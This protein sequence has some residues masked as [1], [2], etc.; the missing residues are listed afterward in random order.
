MWKRIWVLKNHQK[1]LTANELNAVTFERV[2]APFSESY[3]SLEPP[4]F[5]ALSVQ[6]KKTYTIQMEPMYE[7]YL[8]ISVGPS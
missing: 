3:F 1:Y 7:V 6:L 8:E 2:Q 4:K 5:Q